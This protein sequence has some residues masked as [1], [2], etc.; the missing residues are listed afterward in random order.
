MGTE[1]FPTSKDDQEDQEL[2]HALDSAWRAASSQE[3]MLG[4]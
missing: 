2:K 4:F 1:V 3:W